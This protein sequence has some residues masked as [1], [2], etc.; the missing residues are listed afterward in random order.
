MTSYPGFRL[1]RALALGFGILALGA[2]VALVNLETSWDARNRPQPDEANAFVNGTIGTEL[3]PLVVFEV[4]PD[5]FPEEFHPVDSFLKSQGVE[6]PSGGDWVDQYGFIRKELAPEPKDG[7][8]L[9]VGFVLSYHRPG[10]GAPSPVPFV[11]LSCAACHSAEIRTRID[12]PGAVFYGVGNQAMNLLAFSEAVRGI[13]LRRE[14]NNNRQ[15]PYR[16]SLAA[17]EEKLLQKGRS[18]TTTERAM[19]WAWLSASRGELEDYQRVIDEPY[20]PARLFD[21]RFMMAGPGRTQPFRSLVRVH[22]DRPGWWAEGHQMDQGFSKIPVVF[23]QAEEY[24][25][26]WAQFDGTVDNLVARSTL[27]AST[28]GGNVHNLSQPDIASN[29]RKAAYYT[30]ALPSF[31]WKDAF[32]DQ[33][34]IKDDLTN[35]GKGVYARECAYCHGEPAG[36]R[37]WKPPAADIKPASKFGTVIPLSDIGT[38]PDRIQFRHNLEIPAAVTAEFHERFRKNHPLGDF[39]EQDLRNTDGY[40][41]GPISG[42]FL[43]AP[44]LHNASVLTLKE[45]IGLEKRRDFFYRGRNVYDPVSVGFHSPE[46]PLRSDGTPD[47][48]P[49]SEHY[50]F[51]FNTRARGNS[52][53]GHTYPAW[54]YNAAPPRKPTPDEDRELIALLEYLKTL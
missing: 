14:D 3:A 30:A 40:Y 12:R 16:L 39:T 42:T 51:L 45:L 4:L 47:P 44:Y 49:Y 29:V 46:V 48:K 23:H 15:S 5:L 50:Y 43:R 17:V 10:G 13:L 18:L 25:G 31:A 19:I 21:A 2:T 54:G 32:A 28:A 6:K 7:T 26:K 27:A 37:L 34:G 9:P 24:H 35:E 41:A 20:P 8:A 38:D 33:Y 36:K 11:A 53:R 52:N 1:A 22:L